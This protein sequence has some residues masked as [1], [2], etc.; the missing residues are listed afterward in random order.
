VPFHKKLLGIG[1]GLIPGPGGSIIRGIVGGGKEA[2]TRAKWT[3]ADFTAA[4]AQCQVR[5]MAFNT[6]T[7]QCTAI[8][9]TLPIQ[10]G[11][12]ATRQ[13]CALQGRVYNS[14]TR[15][16]G[17]A[18][19]GVDVGTGREFSE[20]TRMGEATMG[21]YGAAMVPD[22]LAISRADCTFDGTVR[23]LILGDDGLCYNKSQLSNK[24]RK[25]PRGRRPLLT[26]GEMRAISIAARAAGRVSRTTKR[27]ADIGMLKKRKGGGYA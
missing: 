1:I 17:E 12:G 7:R 14:S 9:T 13:E 18:T 4:K 16:C 21:R 22:M 11:G 27:L 8:A 26:G 15:T 20:R 19:T 5:G 24:E 6:G 23:G 25:W 10:A 3:E 2:P